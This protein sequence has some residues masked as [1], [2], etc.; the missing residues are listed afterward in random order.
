MQ[1]FYYELKKKKND[2]DK[3]KYIRIL[4][5]KYQVFS[6]DVTVEFIKLVVCYTQYRKNALCV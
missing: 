5:T 4:P 3:V 2:D 1:W 6:S